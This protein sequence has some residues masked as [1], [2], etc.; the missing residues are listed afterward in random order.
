MSVDKPSYEQLAAENQLLKTQLSVLQVMQRRFRATL[1]AIGDAVIAT[2]SMGCV[3][4]MN[5]VAEK[6]TGWT[7]AEAIGKSA[8]EV[9]VIINEYTRD[10]VESPI[11]KVLEEGKVVGLANHTLLIAKDGSEH[12]I[13]DSGAPILDDNGT[14]AGVVLV[15]RDQH[16][17]REAVEIVTAAEERFR[18]FFDNAP[19]GKAMTAPD[20]KLLRVNLAFGEMLGYT[21]D[22]MQSVSFTAITHPDDLPAS[23]EC[24]R[25]L[26]A[27]EAEDWAMDKRYLAKDGR[28]VWTRVSTRLQRDSKGEPVH[29]LTHVLDITE[30]KELSSRYRDLYENAPDMYLSVDVATGLVTQCNDTLCSKTGFSKAEIVNRP[31]FERYAPE[32]LAGAREAFS[33]F[34][35]TGKMRDEELQVLRK[36]GSQ[37][38]ISLNVG[39][40]RDD[41]GNIL[42]SR[43]SW[44]DIS[45]RKRLERD[46]EIQ[47]EHFRLLFQ[48]T[49]IGW[50]EHQ[51]LF[52]ENGDPEDYVFLSANDAFERFTGL[53]RS[54]VLG[55]KVTD[56]IPGIR[57]GD[58][59]LIALYGKVT[60]TGVQEK[61]EI[62][63]APFDKWYSI[64]AFRS[65]E[66]RFVAMFEDVTDRKKWEAD[67]KQLNES[68]TN[69][70]LELEQFAYV[71][72]HDLQEPLRMVASYTQ[73][74][75]QR[76]EGQLDE[77]ADVYIGYA[78]DGARRMQQLINDLLAY[79]RVGTKVKVPV[80]SDCNE[81]VKLVLR[82]LMTAVNESDATVIAEDL[83]FVLAD[84]TQM[85]QLFQN[86]IGNAIKFRGTQLPQVKVSAIRAGDFWEFTVADNGIGIEEKFHERVFTIFQRIHERGKYQG[87]GIGLAIVK[88]IVGRHG[89]SIRLESVPGKGSKF[90][91]TLPAA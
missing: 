49:P 33:T 42:Y 8:D 7:E 9:F 87:T 72:S 74:L 29:F 2:D 37:M 71:A 17:E 11:Q 13:A 60:T 79:S 10:K 6:L 32:S 83:P 27:G 39:A 65:G 5:A 63:F 36:D 68:L 57:E 16:A 45:E 75:A 25:S 64:T 80:P 47:E 15:F 86:L 67:L 88:K 82:N 44:S 89:G 77:K 20:G 61:L 31:V 21:L 41:A 66:G 53:T 69:S 52:D 28:I 4:Q 62:Y 3:Q 43:S 19:V 35:E 78:V 34:R 30:Q 24:V 40:V 48:M 90:I 59:D 76:Y 51:M 18:T 55:K 14:T 91:F 12:P 1:Y 73:L 50:A 46:L 38:D 58:P 56:I 23:I 22:E 84:Q 70:N 81:V 26:L 54:I 85:G